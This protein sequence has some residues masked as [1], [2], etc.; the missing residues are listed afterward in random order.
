MQV[1]IAVAKLR[2]MLLLRDDHFK[3]S[4]RGYRQDNAWVDALFILGNVNG[5]LSHL[6]EHFSGRPSEF[7]GEVGGRIQGA[8]AYAGLLFFL[9]RS[10]ANH[11]LQAGQIARD[12][13]AHDEVFLFADNGV[14]Y[15][16]DQL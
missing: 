5:P 1:T 8:L 13:I 7:R 14:P 3:G 11:R 10:L 9:R 4:A 16:S 15:S 6:A 2:L 12:G